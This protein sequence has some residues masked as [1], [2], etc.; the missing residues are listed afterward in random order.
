MPKIII[1]ILCLNLHI[2]ELLC[3][4][5][6]FTYIHCCENP[7][8]NTH[9]KRLRSRSHQS[10]LDFRDDR[11]EDNLHLHSFLHPKSSKSLYSLSLNTTPYGQ[12]SIS[13]KPTLRTDKLK[14]RTK[15]KQQNTISD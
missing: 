11:Q 2:H 3:V 5:Q 8:Y 7:S 10:R 9:Y 15:W 6:S 12:V 1:S 4:T 14:G 13:T